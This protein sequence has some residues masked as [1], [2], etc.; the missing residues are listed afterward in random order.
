MNAIVCAVVHCEWNDW[1]IGECTESCGGGTRTKMR[2][3]NVSAAYGGEPC[4]G[5]ASIE[6][7]CNIQKCPSNKQ[8]WIVI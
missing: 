7:S 6:E 2:T 4:D 3:E 1:V 5:A 8:I